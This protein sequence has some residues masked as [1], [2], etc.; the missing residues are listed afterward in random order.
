VKRGSSLVVVVDL[1]VVVESLSKPNSTT[2]STTIG[3]VERQ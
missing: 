2:R 1:V 3:A